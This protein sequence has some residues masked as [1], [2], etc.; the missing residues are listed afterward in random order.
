MI[1]GRARSAGAGGKGAPLEEAEE[2]P[3]SA[4]TAGLRL[5]TKNTVDEIYSRVV[6]AADCQM[7]KSWVRSQHPP[8]Q[9]NLRG[10]R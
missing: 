8:V 3:L 2:R 6:R 9:W 1:W 5:K 10:G 7:P 4:E